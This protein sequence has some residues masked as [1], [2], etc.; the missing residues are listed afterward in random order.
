MNNRTRFLNLLEGKDVDRM[1][2]VHFGYWDELLQEWADQGHISRTLARAHYD[3]GPAD[4]QLDKLLG[5]DFCYTARCSARNGL[6]PSF[7]RE[8]IKQD[9]G[10]IYFRNYLGV[11]EMSKKGTNGIPAEIDYLLKDRASFE[12]H[13][14]SRMQYSAKINAADRIMYLRT[15][16]NRRPRGFNYGSVIGTIRSMCT[17]V[18]FSYL[19]YDD[20]ELT[21]EVVDTWNDMQYQCLKHNLDKGF[22][23]DFIHIWE[24]MCFNNGPLISPAKYDELCFKHYK[25]IAELAHAHGIKYISVDCDGDFRALA[26]LWERAGINVMF[27]IEYGT[28]QLDIA[29]VR[30]VAP[31]LLGVG[32]MNKNILSKDFDAVDEEIERLKPLVKLKGYI[33]CPD[34]RLPQGTKFELVKYYT[35]QIKKIL[36]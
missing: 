29:K 17:L 15:L 21:A 27:P 35:E 1:P 20:E 19:M 12:E 9:E 18:G 31:T 22:K 11:V 13:Y 30:E 4:K 10:A 14:K 28:W 8:I 24:D 2:A 25:R 6:M 34:H 33:P 5:W 36:R 16:T 3:G 7:D 23:Y 26:P 32:G